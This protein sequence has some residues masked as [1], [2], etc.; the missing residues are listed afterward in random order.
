MRIKVFSVCTVHSEKNKLKKS[1]TKTI[2][3]EKLRE[4]EAQRHE[5][6]ILGNGER[7][8]SQLEEKTTT[9]NCI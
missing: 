7:R 2:L 3:T 4:L 6:I 9:R 1:N 8:K 5:K